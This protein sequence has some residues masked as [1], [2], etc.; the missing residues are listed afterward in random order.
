ML[1]MCNCFLTEMSIV[2]MIRITTTN[3]VVEEISRRFGTRVIST[4]NDFIICS[5]RVSDLSDVKEPD[6]NLPL[7]KD[8]LENFYKG[9][10]AIIRYFPPNASW[11]YSR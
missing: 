9:K 11:P 6:R 7:L 5:A 3:L 2:I 8:R 10:G 4:D 1:K